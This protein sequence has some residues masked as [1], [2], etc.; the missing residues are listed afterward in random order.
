MKAYESTLQAWIDYQIKNSKY[1]EEYMEDPGLY[2][3]KAE[4]LRVEWYELIMEQAS[5]ARI[6]TKVLDDIVERDGIGVLRS[7]RGKYEKGAE[8]YEPKETRLWDKTYREVLKMAKDGKLGNLANRPNMKEWHR[9]AIMAARM[10]G[11]TIPDRV[12]KEYEEMLK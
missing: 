11:E 5:I 1:S 4:S 6:S 8:G 10:Q 12:M 7:F 9:R 2:K 3:A